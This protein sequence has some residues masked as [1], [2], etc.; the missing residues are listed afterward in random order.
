M[1]FLKNI[2]ARTLWIITGIIFVI[3]VGLIVLLTQVDRQYNT[4]IIVF[5]IIGFVSMTF[6]IQAASFKSFKF[7]PKDIPT[8]EKEY[9]TDVDIISTLRKNKYKEKDKSFGTSFL[10]VA[11]PNAFKVTIVTDINA[12]YEPQDN[13]NQKS[14][15]E[16]D[17]CDRMIGIEIFENY[18][19]EDLVKFKD[20]SLQG[21]NIYYTCLYKVDDN[22]YVCPNYLAPDENHQRNYDALFEELGL[23]EIVK[24][25]APT[26]TEE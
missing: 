21:K 3:T 1:M 25:E 22:K 24:E 14:D 20:Y 9:V 13:D 10:K 17:S 2:K 11:K 12:Y 16:L 23:K 6:L 15:K 19:E 8:I 26:T 4:V 18:R 7:K 5:M